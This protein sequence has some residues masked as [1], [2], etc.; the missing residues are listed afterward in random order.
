MQQEGRHYLFYIF[1]Y[2]TLVKYLQWSRNYY[3]IKKS[4]A[5]KYGPRWEVTKSS[6]KGL[7]SLTPKILLCSSAEYQNPQNQGKPQDG[8]APA[9]AQGGA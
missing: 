9:H 7:K 5:V 4:K 2:L 6:Q 1:I 8:E 3:F